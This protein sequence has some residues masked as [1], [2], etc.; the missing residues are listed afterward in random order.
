M[1]NTSISSA[2]FLFLLT[3]IFSS[4]SQKYSL[5]LIPRGKPDVSIKVTAAENPGIALNKN[6]GIENGVAV[7]SERNEQPVNVKESPILK[8]EKKESPRSKTALK[9][10]EQC[11]DPLFASDSKKL[12]MSRLLTMKKNSSKEGRT[13]HKPLHLRSSAT[14]L[15]VII[16]IFI[17]PLAV[18]LYENSITMNFLIDLILTLLFWL[19]GFIFALWI[20]LR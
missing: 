20:I 12:F 7:K 1:K 10:G 15:L 3:V 19:P 4:C 18:I 9:T 2:F 14:L 13:E 6:E 17:P 11:M 5:S 8:K 16:A